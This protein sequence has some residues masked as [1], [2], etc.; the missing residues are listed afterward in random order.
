MLENMTKNGFAKPKLFRQ[1]FKNQENSVMDQTL[2]NNLIERF[3]VP[4]AIYEGEVLSIRTSERSSSNKMSSIKVRL[5]KFI[6][7]AHSGKHLYQP[8]KAHGHL[9]EKGGYSEREAADIG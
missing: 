1:P 2:R 8:L 6:A 3:I 5:T 9:Y 7:L 4:N